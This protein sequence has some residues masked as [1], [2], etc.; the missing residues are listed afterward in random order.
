MTPFRES[1]RSSL[2]PRATHPHRKISFND[3]PWRKISIPVT[4]NSRYPLLRKIFFS[5]LSFDLRWMNYIFYTYI[6][7]FLV[8]RELERV[9]VRNRCISIGRRAVTKRFYTRRGFIDPFSRLTIARLKAK[10][11]TSHD[12]SYYRSTTT[13]DYALLFQDLL[14]L[15]RN[16]HIYIYMRNSLVRAHFQIRTLASRTFIVTIITIIILFVTS[17]F[18]S[19]FRFFLI[20]FFFFIKIHDEDEDE[21]EDDEVEQENDAWSASESTVQQNHWSWSLMVTPDRGTKSV[22]YVRNDTRW[23][24]TCIDTVNAIMISTLFSIAH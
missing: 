6:E 19:F 17:F 7:E 3:P 22:T 21:D 11:I 18:L 5:F 10:R 1:N 4:E 15:A 24:D 13:N 8:R 12:R 9:G 14:S 20:L 23:N 2:R 16:N